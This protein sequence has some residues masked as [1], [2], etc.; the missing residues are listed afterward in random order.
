MLVVLNITTS[1]T[2]RQHRT[3]AEPVQD[4]PQPSRR[5]ASWHNAGKL[6][7]YAA[8]TVLAAALVILTPQMH[9]ETDRAVHLSTGN[10]SAQE[11]HNS[12]GQHRP[13][14]VPLLG[15]NEGLLRPVGPQFTD[16]SMS[17]LFTNWLPLTSFRRQPRRGTQQP[18]WRSSLQLHYPTAPHAAST[19]YHA[20]KLPSQL[21]PASL[22]S[23]L[24][25][26]TRHNQ[27]LQ[28]KLA[29]AAETVRLY[30]DC[31]LRLAEVKSDL[32][33]TS[34]E[35]R[36]LSAHL[37]SAV[38]QLS[39]AGQTFTPPTAD[40]KQGIMTAWQ[41]GVPSAVILLGVVAA[42]W[43]GSSLKKL[44]RQEDAEHTL[45]LQEL[46]SLQDQVCQ[47]AVYGCVN[48]RRY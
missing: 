12:M 48:K 34:E 21:S 30:D 24:A 17:G 5:A 47:V 7:S 11:R 28:I 19:Q 27:Q 45:R 9:H 18:N 15:M 39:A 10:S 1:L 3:S 23:S 32:A 29:A 4:L 35:T 44:E 42:L 14:A 16:F 20:S 37:V 26:I 36:Q 13:D 22:P 38:H 25:H 6:S 2:C 46:Q 31:Q 41:H 40:S 8:L 33:R 43:W